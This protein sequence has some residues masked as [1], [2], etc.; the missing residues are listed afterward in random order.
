MYVDTMEETLEEILENEVMGS[1]NHGYI[2]LRLGGLLDRLGLFTPVGE[3]SLDVSGI[4]LSQFD[5]RSKTELIPDIALYPKRTLSRPTDIQR[6]T[7]M[8]LIAIEI[9]SPRQGFDEILEKFK[10]YFALGISSCWLVAPA[11][12]TI[13][14]Y[15]SPTDWVTFT[16]GDLVDETVGIRLAL[17]EIFA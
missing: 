15:R 3:L 14:V 16:Q 11:I 10:A 6:M 2:Q 5:L 7:E 17:T 9:L 8:P 4:D 1:F 13:S 12:N